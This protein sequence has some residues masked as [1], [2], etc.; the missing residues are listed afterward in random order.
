MNDLFKKF[1]RRMESPTLFIVLV[2]ACALSII[3]FASGATPNPGHA[4]TGIGNGLWQASSSQSQLRTYVFPDTNTEILTSSSSVTFLQRTIST[5]TTLSAANDMIVYVD[6]SSSP[7]TVTLPSASGTNIGLVFI[8]KK[9]DAA[10]ANLVT[11]NPLGSQTI[12]GLTSLSFANRGE[13]AMF[14]S[15]GT[16]WRIVMRRDYDIDSFH[17]RGSTAN[18]FYTSPGAGTALTTGA[19]VANTLYAMPLV[20]TKSTTIDTMG[21]N[22]TT[23]VIGSSAE[24][25]IYNDNGNEYPGTLVVDIGSF[26]TATAAVVTSSANLPVTLDAGLYWMVIVDTGAPSL[27]AFAAGSATPILGYASSLPTNAQ[28]GWTASFTKGALPGTYPAG[29]TTIVGNP[30]PALYVRFSQ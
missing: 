4:W 2:F 30:D 9:I 13:A 26:S 14:E 16:I 28:F 5:S 17:T 23:R 6:A 11:I 7:I 8:I 27:R 1:S 24:V 29:G 3:L 25:G 22:V 10:L 18:Q 12:D 21:F 19:L 15:D 20:L